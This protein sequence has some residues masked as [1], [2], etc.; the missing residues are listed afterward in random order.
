[1]NIYTVKF[2][3]TVKICLKIKHN[4]PTE[5]PRVQSLLQVGIG[6]LYIL[7]GGNLR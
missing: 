2:L 3:T 4:L 6:K 5:V 7:F 1:M